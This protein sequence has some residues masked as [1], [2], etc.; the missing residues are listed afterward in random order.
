VS[1]VVVCLRFSFTF[2]YFRWRWWT[3]ARS[4]RFPNETSPFVSFTEWVTGMSFDAEHF[5]DHL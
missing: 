2:S 5:S 4:G 3:N 1:Y